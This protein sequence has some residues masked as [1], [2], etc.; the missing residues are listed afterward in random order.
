MTYFNYHATIKKLIAQGKLKF[1]YISPN[2]NGIKPA[3]VLVFDDISHPVMPIRE[4]KWQEY[5]DIIPKEK[6][7]N[8]VP[9]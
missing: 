4:N 5:F 8:K 6:F 7:I 3:L 9:K 2:H 1:W